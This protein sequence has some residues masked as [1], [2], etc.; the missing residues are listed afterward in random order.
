MALYYKNKG[1]GILD[2]RKKTL[3]LFLEPVLSGPKTPPTP[4]YAGCAHMKHSVWE[5][6]QVGAWEQGE[7]RYGNEEAS[8]RQRSRKQ[9]NWEHLSLPSEGG[10]TQG[11]GQ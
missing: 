6:G 8:Y 9:A 1:Q 7:Q 4:T 3:C 2:R 5:A 11:R 10:G